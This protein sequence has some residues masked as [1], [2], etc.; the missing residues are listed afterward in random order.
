MMVGAATFLAG[1]LF[2]G[3][4]LSL[5]AGWLLADRLAARGF[6]MPRADG[7]LGHIDGIR[8]YLAL[9]VMF[10]HFIAWSRLLALSIP[11]GVGPDPM[12]AI[13]QVPV[14]MFFMITGALFYPVAQAGLRGVH[15]PGFAVKRIFRIYP[16][17][18]TSIALVAG[19]VWWRSGFSTEPR[20]LQ[21]TVTNLAV[22]ASFTAQPELFGY[23]YAKFVN[24]GVLW[25]LEAELLFYLAVLPAMAILRD[26][27][28]KWLPAWTTPLWALPIALV[29]R[30]VW[31]G[32]AEFMIAFMLGMI[33]A[34]ARENAR[35]CQFFRRA[36][37]A[38][39]AVIVAAAAIALLPPPISDRTA[40]F[41]APLL[42]CIVCG[43]GFRGLLVHR[44]SIVL[45]E[46]SFG[47][48]LLHGI[49]LWAG[50]EML[51][52]IAVE[53]P[54]AVAVIGLPLVAICVIAVSALA[55]C[56]VERPMIAK[57][58]HLAAALRR[59]LA[60]NPRTAAV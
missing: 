46:I 58:R 28:R 44:A 31:P 23:D 10:C 21:T 57:G 29:L 18:L 60:S 27:T 12:K 59:G 11:W 5:V 40:L 2:V 19:L 9:S 38:G 20:M 13:G 35:L 26:L 14:I 53:H 48:Y 42:A 52:P 36:D 25:T 8:G 15:W 37:V 24:A 47:I 22:W 45:G 32:H 51:G 30:Q 3:V 50:A 39:V 56:A 41:Y 33:V 16:L 6:P 49:A 4:C 54:F 17:A 7:R 1:S 34:D 55:H 43:Q